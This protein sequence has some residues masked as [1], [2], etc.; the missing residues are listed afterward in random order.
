MDKLLQILVLIGAG[1]VMG[2][3]Q[4]LTFWILTALGIIFG[5]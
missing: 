5:G 1:V 4:Y 3:G 2:V